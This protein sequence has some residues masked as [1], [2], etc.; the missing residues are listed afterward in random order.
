V[1][2]PLL[3]DLASGST[4][5]RCR[6][7]LELGTRADPAAAEALIAAFKKESDDYVRETLVRALV[8]V[9]DLVVEPLISLLTSDNRQLRHHAAHALSKLRDTRAVD[10]LIAALGDP[11]P[12]VVYKAAF[13]LGRIG[14]SR[15][16]GSLIVLL[17]H[18]A[19]EVRAAASDAL[20]MIGQAAVPALVAAFDQG[21]AV[22]REQVVHLLATVAGPAAEEIAH[23]AAHDETAPVRMAGLATLAKVTGDQ[24][25]RAAASA[26]LND[27]DA[28]VRALASRL[29][30]LSQADR[31]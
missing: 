5:A 16:I 12:S 15:A 30:K 3:D 7:A 28:G 9:G 19:T 31:S 11:E 23:R 2:D 13:A 20:E 29:L 17:D 22:V 27:S 4:H 21:S 8:R 18:T 24:T 26:A 10:P 14:D 1:S 25:V 6:A